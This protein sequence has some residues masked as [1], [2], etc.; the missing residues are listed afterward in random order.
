MSIPSLSVNRYDRY[1]PDIRDK[2]VEKLR[3]RLPDT[4]Y[5]VLTPALLRTLADTVSANAPALSFYLQLTPERRIDGTWRTYLASMSDATLKPIDDRRTRQALQEEFDRIQQA[6]EAELPELGRGV[7][8]C[9]CR[10]LGL[11]QQ[12]AV[13]L[14]LTDGA[15]RGSR[16]YV[17]LLVR[18]QDEHDRFV[19]ALL[20]QE[21][22]R[23]FISQ[24][25]Q[26][27]EVFEVK[28]TTMRRML[29]DHG[30]KDRYDGG[31][32]QAISNEAH[33]LAHASELAL[34]EYECRYL[35]L[36]EAE[37]LRAAVIHDL[38]K[39]VQQRVGAEFAA[40]VHARPAE[41]AAAAEPAQHAIEEREETA[42]VRRLL[43]AGPQRS[44]WGVQAT[45]VALWESRVATLVVDDMF[46]RPGARCGEC[47]AL[48]EAA[49]ESCPV[50]GNN[51]VEPVDDVVELA[52][53]Q[54]LDE[55]GAF[56]MVRSQTARQSLGQIGPM[57]ALL[58]W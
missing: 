41:V 50:C 16:P 30:P 11:W 3:T 34:T 52:I 9:A 10:Q 35:L 42:T 54:A 58:R 45:L 4:A 55:D 22:S 29:R 33:I 44:A 27:D 6:M 51:A 48:L 2:I 25:G 49:R 57:A 5:H 13:P 19:I 26:I 20:T 15:Y 28:R 46:A 43:D 56:E 39:D 21:L 7:A 32:L 12:I 17:R 36:A 38:G 23:F 1:T 8:F 31:V 53:E 24:I 40:E 14:P 37:D 47:A 18:T